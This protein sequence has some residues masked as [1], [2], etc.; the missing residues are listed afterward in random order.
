MSAKGNFGHSWPSEQHASGY[1]CLKKYDF[2][3]VFSSD[4]K[5][6]WNHCQVI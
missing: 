4:F 2:L 1:V 5:S 3:L 6:R